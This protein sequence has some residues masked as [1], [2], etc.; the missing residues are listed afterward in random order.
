MIYERV[1]RPIFNFSDMNA[2]DESTA[3]FYLDIGYKLIHHS[4]QGTFRE[5]RRVPGRQQGVRITIE[6][7]KYSKSVCLILAGN[8]KLRSSTHLFTKM[9]KEHKDSALR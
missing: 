1:R 7:P 6:E 8:Y 5:S 2:K 3:K 9:S 4:Y